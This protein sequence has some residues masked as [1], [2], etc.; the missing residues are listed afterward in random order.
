M[1]AARRRSNGWQDTMKSSLRR[2]AGVP[3]DQLGFTLIEIAVVMVI[4]GLLAVGGVSLM[5]LLTERKAR[6]EALAYLKETQTALI[7][8]AERT[9]RLPYADGDGDGLENNGATAG[10][11]P[12]RT[13]QLGPADPYKR[14]LHY[15][16]N[17]NL[18]TSRTASCAALRTGLTGAPQAVDADGAPAAFPTAAVLVS[19]GPM[20]ADGDGNVFDDLAVGTH[21]GDNTDGTPNYLRHPP[22]AGFDDLVVYLGGNELYSSLCEYLSLAVNNHSGSLVY[23]YDVN[24]GSDLGSLTTGNSTVYTVLSGSRLELR[25]GSG[26]GGSLVSS[27]PPTPIALAGRGLTITLP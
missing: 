6:N 5:R 3:G 22:V 26:G 17:P 10:A 15:A 24:Q 25:S 18:G 27:N 16:L 12:Y 20:D 19:A 13:L 1:A 2:S 8:F 11:L 14:P 21:Q 4:I 23:V 9:G 7:G